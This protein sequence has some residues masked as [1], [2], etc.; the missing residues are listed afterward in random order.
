VFGSTQTHDRRVRDVA[1]RACT[2]IV[3]TH[4]SRSPEA[5]YPTAVE[6]CCTTLQMWGRYGEHS[7]AERGPVARWSSAFDLLCAV[8]THI[9]SARIQMGVILS[10][11]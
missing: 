5:R 1:V 8:L 4:Y 9:V 7:A 10:S 2:A 3:F 11:G 6:E